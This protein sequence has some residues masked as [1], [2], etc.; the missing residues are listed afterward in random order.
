MREMVLDRAKAVVTDLMKRHKIDSAR[1][2]WVGIADLEPLTTN[3]TEIGR[4]RNRR[5][6]VVKR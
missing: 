2:T 1:L 4:A 6:E 3:E 5:V